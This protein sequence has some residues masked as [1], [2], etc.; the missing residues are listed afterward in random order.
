V[1]P[2]AD[3]PYGRLSTVICNDMGYPALVRQAGQ[4]GADILF[5]PTN[6]IRPYAAGDAAEAT[7]RTIENGFSMVR[8]TANGTSLITSYDGR[9][10]ASQAYFT[11]D[12]GIML[13][14][15]PT[16]GVT[17]IYSRIGDV[18]AY[19]CV[20]GLIFL[21]GWAFVRRGQPAA[22]AQGQPA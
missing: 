9:V 21:A 19:L 20:L 10:L 22:V 5:A 6:D 8:A 15:I 13:A 11:S 12:S 4:N 7:Y 17:T 1:V 3:T 2:V 16:H 18:F 14:S